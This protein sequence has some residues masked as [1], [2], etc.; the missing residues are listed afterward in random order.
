MRIVSDGGVCAATDVAETAAM[1]AMAPI[2][3]AVRLPMEFDL[4]EIK[5]CS[6]AKDEATSVNRTAVY[7]C[8][9]IRMTM[10]RRPLFAEINS[11][12]HIC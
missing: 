12:L 3:D 7:C 6:Q 8:Q 4:P 1:V 5:G 9:A 10:L 2:I 11:K